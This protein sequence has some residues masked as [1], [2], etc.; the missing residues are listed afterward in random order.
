M[1]LVVLIMMV[2]MESVDNAGDVQKDHQ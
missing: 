1:F 2:V